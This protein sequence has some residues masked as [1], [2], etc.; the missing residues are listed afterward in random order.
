MLN[1]GKSHI[2]MEVIFV[3]FARLSENIANVTNLYCLQYI[4]YINCLQKYQFYVRLLSN[5]II[6][7][8]NYKTEKQ[9]STVILLP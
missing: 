5:L 4:V 6:Q 9:F 1:L 8:I 3:R 7:I 2:N